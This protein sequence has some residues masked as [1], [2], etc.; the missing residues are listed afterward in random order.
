[1]GHAGVKLLRPSIG[2]AVGVKEE[3]LSGLVA[4]KTAQNAGRL[5]PCCHP[6]EAPAPH[7]R[8]SAVALAADTVRNLATF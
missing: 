7:Q 2:R 8:L 5:Q 6:S 3:S 1:M 4:S